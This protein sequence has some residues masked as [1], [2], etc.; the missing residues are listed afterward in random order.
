MATVSPAENL[1]AD[2]PPV[3]TVGTPRWLLRGALLMLVVV[4]G[5]CWVL[6]PTTTQSVFTPSATDL[7]IS[8]LQ[9]VEYGEAQFFLGDMP[10]GQPLADEAA[11]R[12]AIASQLNGG[13]KT[14]LVLRVSGG[15]YQQRVQRACQI[16]RSAWPAGKPVKIELAPLTQSP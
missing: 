9:S 6:R 12:A 13:Q 16:V 8:M 4:G 5:L 7:V 11:L 15:V 10:G 2:I 1:P 14:K 3:H